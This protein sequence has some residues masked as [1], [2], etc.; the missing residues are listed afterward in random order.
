MVVRLMTLVLMLAGPLGHAQSQ[1]DDAGQT[2]NRSKQSSGESG[3]PAP[4]AQAVVLPDLSVPANASQ[5]QL[6][7]VIIA[8]KQFTP[9]SPDELLKLHTAIRDASIQ[10]AKLLKDPSTPRYQAA[11]LDE[12]TSSVTLMATSGPDGI[13]KTRKN[14]VEYLQSRKEIS[15]TDLQMGMFVATYLEMQPNKKPARETYNLMIDLLAD[16]ERTE[17][18][19]LRQNLLASVRRLD[20]LG[21]KLELKAKAIDGSEITTEKF[22]GKFVIVDFFATWCEHCLGEVPR[23]RSHLE[24]Y[25]PQGLAVVGISL[26][27]NPKELKEYI[28]KANLPWPVIHDSHSNPFATLR[29]KFGVAT[30]PTVMLLNKEGVVVSLEARGAELDRLMQRIFE[31]P[32]V[33][34]APSAK[35]TEIQ[36]GKK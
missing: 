31:Q 11:K 13:E 10:L 23:L 26:D 4:D 1:S 24:K 20:L 3:N 25:G 6:E 30:L 17:M 28:D 14:Y 16:D 21:N 32:T 18:K 12:L 29:M 9:R 34:E 22:A 35:P 33:A 19:S 27:E 2:Q 7:K 5:D 8:A 15:I 36:P